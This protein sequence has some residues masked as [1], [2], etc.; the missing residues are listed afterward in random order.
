MSA[1]ELATAAP[2][3]K[4]LA[5]SVHLFTA[6]GGVFGA[7][8]LVAIAR[9]DLAFAGIMMLL[10][11]AIDAVDGSMA[12]AVGVSE[13]LPKVDGRRLDDI[14]DFVN[15]VIV[16]VVFMAAAGSL[17]HW[18]FIALPVLASS[19]GFSQ[20]D[21]KTEDDFFLGFPSY[22]NVLALYLWLLELSPAAGDAWLLGLSIAVF[23]PLKY[24]YPSKMQ[25]LR[26][27]TCVGGALWTL[28]MVWVISIPDA[29]PRINAA[30]ISLVYPAYY[31]ALSVWLG[32]WHEAIA[33]G[34]RREG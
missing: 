12:R 14:I 28:A 29:A 27:S 34:L 25:V 17:T 16:P 4:I 23:I 2:Q 26:I 24:I 33:G 5:W 22:W 19:Y 6:S 30:W 11:M 1:S 13:V 18:F 10:T 15:F 31:I 8:A 9:D 3:R 21:A 7:L 20:F 32:R